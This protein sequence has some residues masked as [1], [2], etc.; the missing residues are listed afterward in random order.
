MGFDASKNTDM[1]ATV[2]NMK[3]NTFPILSSSYTSENTSV[4]AQQ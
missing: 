3:L 4:F 1:D 2:K